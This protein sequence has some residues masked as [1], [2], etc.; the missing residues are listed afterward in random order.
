MRR[1]SK[2]GNKVTSVTKLNTAAMKDLIDAGY[3]IGNATF[4][5]LVVATI[6]VNSTKALDNLRLANQDMV[7]RLEELKQDLPE[8]QNL[9]DEA[10]HH[11]TMLRNRV[12][13]STNA[14]Y[15]RWHH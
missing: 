5:N 8:L 13:I 1:Q 2:F 12:S 14:M 3:D 4:H 7:D 11:T 15:K 10:T 6:V 9:T